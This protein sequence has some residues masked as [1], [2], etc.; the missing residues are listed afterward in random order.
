M[1]ALKWNL[2]P[3]QFLLILYLCPHV[4]ASAISCTHFLFHKTL[5]N[6]TV[7]RYRAFHY[8]VIYRVFSSLSIALFI[9]SLLSSRI[10]E[11]MYNL[12]AFSWPQL[13]PATGPWTTPSVTP[14]SVPPPC[15]RI[16][17]C[18]TRYVTNWPAWLHLMSSFWGVFRLLNS[19]LS[20]HCACLWTLDDSWNTTCRSG[21]L[22]YGIVTRRR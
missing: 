5:D 15:H 8:F 2:A 14:H 18:D 16:I 9:A 19:S 7:W 20:S 3:L 13:L 4:S 10:T 1:V 11:T 21:S 17:I 22:E 12:H 6:H